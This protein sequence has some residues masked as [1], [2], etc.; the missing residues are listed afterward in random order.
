M[1]RQ[2]STRVTLVA[3]IANKNCAA[4]ASHIGIRCTGNPPHG[5]G[6]QKQERRG[7][8]GERRKQQQQ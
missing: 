2:S 5:S 1:Q 8:S 3:A 7:D 4:H 6:S